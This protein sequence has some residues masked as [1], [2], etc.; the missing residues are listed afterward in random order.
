[1]SGA[2]VN[3]VKFTSRL[4]GD[5][6]RFPSKAQT[7]LVYYD[8]FNCQ[9]RIIG[10]T[11]GDRFNTINQINGYPLSVRFV[12]SSSYYNPPIVYSAMSLNETSSNTTSSAMTSKVT[13]ALAA[14]PVVILAML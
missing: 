11:T 14:V 13:A 12:Q 6:F 1:L 5:P 3:S 2:Q 4:G 9:G 7:T 8:N 10:Q